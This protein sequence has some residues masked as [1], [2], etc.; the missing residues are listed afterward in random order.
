MNFK[1]HIQLD[2][3]FMVG[4]FISQPLNYTKRLDDPN[5]LSLLQ[6]KCLSNA[7]RIEMRDRGEYSENFRY[8]PI[9]KFTWPH[10]LGRSLSLSLSPSHTLTYFHINT[11]IPN[12]HTH[13]HSDALIL[14]CS[15]TK[16]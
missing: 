16:S 1:I 4:V 11:D 9:G 15:L 12:P 8:R 2:K 10:S 14:S 6:S 3:W 13:S 7:Y 5:L